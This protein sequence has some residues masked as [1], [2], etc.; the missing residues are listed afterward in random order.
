MAAAARESRAARLGCA[1]VVPSASARNASRTARARRRSAAVTVMS[2]ERARAPPESP[3]LA[4]L[5]QHL[6]PVLVIDG[7]DEPLHELQPP[8]RRL[9][10][11]HIRDLVDRLH[12][13]PT[14]A[15]AV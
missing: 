4:R 8:G 7:V 2:A 6:A 12:D 3:Q 10:V 14:L 13:A 11:V 9:V 15:I 1:A 5:A